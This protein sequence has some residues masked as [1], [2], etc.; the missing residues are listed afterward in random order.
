MKKWYQER[1]F[2]KTVEERTKK[3]TKT[4]KTKGVNKKW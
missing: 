1:N 3:K 2:V 4:I